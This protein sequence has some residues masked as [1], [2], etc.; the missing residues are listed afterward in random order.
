V[1]DQITW[2]KSNKWFR[3][4]FIDQDLLAW[5]ISSILDNDILECDK[6]FILIDNMLLNN[7][8]EHKHL[9]L[10]SEFRRKCNIIPVDSFKLDQSLIC[11][12]V[13]LLTSR[14]IDSKTYLDLY[15]KSWL[16]HVKMVVVSTCSDI[17]YYPPEYLVIKK[18]G[19]SIIVYERSSGSLKQY[20][21]RMDELVIDYWIKSN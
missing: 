13:V 14:C 15:F 11:E 21:L 6:L 16:K 4:L 17:E 8:K 19:D 18:L 3:I 5:F 7:V 12:C 20:R 1:I 2:F 10:N 9:V